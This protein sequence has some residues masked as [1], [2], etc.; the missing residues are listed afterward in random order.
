MGLR[1][2]Q[3]LLRLV[4]HL[5]VVIRAIHTHEFSGAYILEAEISWVG[6]GSE[7]TDEEDEPVAV[8]LR[9]DRYGPP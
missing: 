4:P 6:A 5:R 7:S 1:R 2:L 3:Q 9:M 8:W